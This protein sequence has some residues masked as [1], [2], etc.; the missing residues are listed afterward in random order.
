MPDRKHWLNKL[1]YCEWYIDEIEK[2][3]P[4]RRLKPK[5]L[6]GLTN[7]WSHI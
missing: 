4:W 2:G 7:Q 5:L 6:D 3:I 1:S